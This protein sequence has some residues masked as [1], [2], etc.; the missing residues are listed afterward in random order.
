MT[1]LQIQ[2]I[3]ELILS[4]AFQFSHPKILPRKN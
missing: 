2:L 1:E 3:K 4:Y